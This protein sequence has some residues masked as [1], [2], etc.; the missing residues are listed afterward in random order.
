LELRSMPAPPPSASFWFAGY[1]SLMREIEQKSSRRRRPRWILRSPAILRTSNRLRMASAWVGVL[2]AV[3]LC[4][5][6]ASTVLAAESALPGDRLYGLKTAVEDV[7]LAVT[8][9]EGDVSLHARFAGRRLGEIEALVAASRLAD[10]PEAAAR[11]ETHVEQAIQALAAME[12]KDAGA[13]EQLAADLDQM[14]SEQTAA[15]DALTGQM[16]AQMVP[17]IQQ[18]QS[19]SA[20][21]Q[22]AIKQLRTEPDMG[23]TPKPPDLTPTRPLPRA[24]QPPPASTPVPPAEMKPADTPAA[25]LTPD[26]AP[27]GPAPADT[28]AAPPAPPGGESPGPSPASTPAAPPAPPPPGGEPPRPAPAGPPMTDAG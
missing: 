20:D 12:D 22:S 19:T 5:G 10:V 28:A 21:A 7:R 6:T 23:G 3:I 11:Y 17:L 26:G 2:V 24:T 18:V 13:R 16:P 4:L 8:P 14:L 25:L 1:H 15:W 27:A 9:A